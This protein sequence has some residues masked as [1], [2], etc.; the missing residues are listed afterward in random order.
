M[1]QCNI[2]KNIFSRD[3]ENSR[4]KILDVKIVLN[5]HVSEFII[6]QPVVIKTK[7]LR[8]YMRYGIYF[9]M[10]DQFRGNLMLIFAK[11]PALDHSAHFK[12]NELKFF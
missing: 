6:H 8:F 1:Y 11:C 9:Q 7:T 4:S 12:T 2:E 10:I 3:G 5:F